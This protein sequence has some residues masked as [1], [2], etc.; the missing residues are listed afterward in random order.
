MNILVLQ[1]AEVEHPGSLR[2]L[3]AVDGHQWSA[4]RLDAGES[5]PDLDAFDALW[6][7]GGPMDV[8]QEEQFP[9]LVA[10]KAFIRQAV[11]ERSMPF[12]GLCLGHQLLAEALGGA[13][14]PA[15]TS[16]VGV[17]DIELTAAGR[18]SDF[19]RGFSERFPCLQW[20]GA[21]VSRLPAGATCLAR[22][23]ACE[24]Q[25]MSW[26]RSALSLQFHLEVESDTVGNWA[27]LPDYAAALESVFGVGGAERLNADCASNMT[28]F[29]AAVQLLFGNW[30]R[31]ADQAA[32][33]S[34]IDSEPQLRASDRP[35]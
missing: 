15:S 35:A 19:F 10:E 23:P 7:L 17:M 27:E 16:E 4:V 12:L 1:H 8:W 13:C 11:V 34:V 21:E 32:D 25:A 6:V 28:T 5:L 3:L 29:D 14:Q 26:S 2:H 22:S 9:W 24:I 33:S 31:V 18:G 30:M 20:H